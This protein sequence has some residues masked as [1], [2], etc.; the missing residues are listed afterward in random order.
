M[1]Y[2]TFS[3]LASEDRVPQKKPL[4]F[5]RGTERLMRVMR[6]EPTSDIVSLA[7]KERSGGREVKFNFPINPTVGRLYFKGILSNLARR[8]LN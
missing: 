7:N 5:F 6:T 1:R 8:A 2:P 4:E 3:E